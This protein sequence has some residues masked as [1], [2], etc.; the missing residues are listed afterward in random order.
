MHVRNTRTYRI[1]YV[2][3][4]V[5]WRY[6]HLPAIQYRRLTDDPKSKI[7]GGQK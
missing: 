3:G 4:K 7:N 5:F 1:D 6:F 2:S